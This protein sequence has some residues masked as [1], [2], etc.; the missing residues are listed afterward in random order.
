MS[1]TRIEIS[2]RT[3][4]FAILFI[5]FLQFL[6]LVKDLIFSLF[7]AFIIVSALRPIV[8]FLVNKHFSR[9]LAT[10]IVYLVFL[11]V[12]IGILILIIPPLLTESANLFK[13]LPAIIQ[14]TIP[15]LPPYI[16]LNSLTQYLPNVTTQVVDVL[17]RI[18]SNAIFLLTTLVFSFYLLLEENVVAKISKKLLDEKAARR[19]IVVFDR[20]EKR[21]NAWFWGQAALMLTIGIMS[22]IGLTAIN[23][24][25][26][27]P[28][29]VLAGLLEVVPNIG[30]ILSLIP[31]FL[32]GIS[33]S[34]VLG[35]SMIAL[36]FIIQLLENHIIVPLVMR[37]A[38]GLSP[39]IT[40]IALIVGGKLAGVI[41]VLLSVPTTLFV[42]TILIEILQVRKNL[43]TDR[44]VR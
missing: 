19:I 26:A 38:V 9:I 13:S 14:M 2:W 6:L 16:S 30:P 12:I 4:V 32:I 21:M 29:A 36:Y 40:L 1:T 7:I 18:F 15:K 33:Q 5:L 23:M 27:L 42:G 34:F 28:L 22:F 17:Q 10:V 31:A 11:A 24:R 43:S 35:L 41:G 39:L 20:A 37:K 25:Y 8:D 3:I 44:Q